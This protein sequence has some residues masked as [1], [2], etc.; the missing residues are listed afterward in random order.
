MDSLAQEFGGGVTLYGTLPVFNAVGEFALRSPLTLRAT[1][2]AGF[3]T[4]FSLFIL[5]GGVLYPLSPF[6]LGSVNLLP[7]VGGGGGVSF[8]SFPC[9]PGF[10]GLG[11]IL[12]GIGGARYPLG[13]FDLF[14]ELR[15][16]IGAFGVFNIVGTVGAL[17]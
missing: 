11:F 6:S 1:F 16:G 17:F 9:C 4:G 12:Q 8:L 2:G 7:Y 14:G 5:D 10:G 15:A 3:G 13:N